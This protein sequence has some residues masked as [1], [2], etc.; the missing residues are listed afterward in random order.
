MRMF[1]MFDKFLGGPIEKLIDY[2]NNTLVRNMSDFSALWNR[3]FRDC[4]SQTIT[5][6]DNDGTH[7]HHLTFEDGVLKTYLL[8]TN[9]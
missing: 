7:Y 1:P 9:P 5:V 6:A 3:T 2:I 4:V 8:D